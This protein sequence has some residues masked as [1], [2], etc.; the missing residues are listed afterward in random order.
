MVI[1]DLDLLSSQL[2]QYWD[3]RCATS[4]LE[5]NQIFMHARPAP[6]RFSYPQSLFCG[7]VVLKWDGALE[8]SPRAGQGQLDQDPPAHGLKKPL[9]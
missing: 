9:P 1:T 4:H 3:F 2:L 7:F 5:G 8:G 6:H